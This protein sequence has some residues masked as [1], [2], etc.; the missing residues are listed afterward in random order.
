MLRKEIKQKL[1]SLSTRERAHLDLQVSLN[2]KKLLTTLGFIQMKKLIGCFAPFENEPDW[3][4]SFRNGREFSKA[5]DDLS[6]Y[7]TFENEKMLFK[8]SKEKDLVLRND[9]KANICGP[10]DESEKVLP[11]I[12]LVPGL[13]FG[14][15]G[16]RLGRGKGFY[17][18]YLSQMNVTCI[19]VC[20]ESQLIENIPMEKFD[21]KM[22]YVVT[23]QK[24]YTIKKV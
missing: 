7:P 13:A 18:H 15:D 19:G 5:L 17:D 8:L 11:E 10:K 4:S 24:I 6:A 14:K 2:L 1:L 21:Y 9:F 12:F 3:K 23:D 16:E 22:N 20:F